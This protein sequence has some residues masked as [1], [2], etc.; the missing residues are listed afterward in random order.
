MPSPVA[1][2]QQSGGF[3]IRCMAWLCMGFKVKITSFDIDRP[4]SPETISSSSSIK[5]T[6][7]VPV[8]YHLLL[9]V[10]LVQIVHAT[11]EV[12]HVKRLINQHY[13]DRMRKP[14]AASIGIFLIAL[15]IKEQ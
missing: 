12:L 9:P 13:T 3:G 2:P 7:S 1:K 15:R 5:P 4:K 10:R 14:S 6:F 8:H 11:L